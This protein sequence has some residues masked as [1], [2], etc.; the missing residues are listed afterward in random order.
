MYF[1]IIVVCTM[2][3]SIEFSP[4]FYNFIINKVHNSRL[5]PC[6][7]RNSYLIRNIKD[8]LFLDEAE[9]HIGHMAILGRK[10]GPVPRFVSIQY[11]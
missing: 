9:P 4:H 8:L 6:S 5:S 3:V 2:F 10:G 11:S 7:Y 1:N